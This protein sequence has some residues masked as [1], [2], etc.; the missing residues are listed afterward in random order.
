MY[1]STLSIFFSMAITFHFLPLSFISGNFLNQRFATWFFRNI[2]YC[3]VTSFCQYLPIF[4]LERQIFIE[5]D[6]HRQRSSIYWLSL[7]VA[8]GA[9]AGG[10]YT[11]AGSQGF[12]IQTGCQ[13]CGGVKHLDL[14]QSLYEIPIL[15]REW[16]V[17]WAH[18]ECPSCIVSSLKCQNIFS[19]QPVLR[20]KSPQPPSNLFPNNNAPAT[21]G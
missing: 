8:T 20:K 19:Y 12:G 1:Y 9:E 17:K 15:A 6:W 10:S 13:V 14:N 2:A 16:L 11:G 5:K 18:C 21:C 7:W 4:L 3:I